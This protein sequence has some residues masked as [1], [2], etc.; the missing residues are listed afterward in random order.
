MSKTVFIVNIGGG[1]LGMQKI[2]NFSLGYVYPIVYFTFLQPDK[3]DLFANFV[4]ELIET[5]PVLLKRS[6]KLRQ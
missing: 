1:F 2:V 6:I 3:N 4:A 5:N